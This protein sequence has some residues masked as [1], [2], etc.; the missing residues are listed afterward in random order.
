TQYLRG[1]VDESELEDDELESGSGVTPVPPGQETLTAVQQALAE[2]LQVSEELL[3]AAVRHSRAASPAPYGVTGDEAAT[4]VTLLP[5]DRHPECCVCLALNEGG[6]SRLL[7]KGLREL[8]QRRPEGH[9][10]RQGTSTAT[11]PPWRNRSP[12][13]LSTSRAWPPGPMGARAAR[14]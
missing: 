9:G 7:V 13:P 5:P 11:T 4:W 1:S 2:L 8:S 14:S 6:L 10:K 12:T 3:A